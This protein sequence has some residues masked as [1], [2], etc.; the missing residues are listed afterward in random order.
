MTG[1]SGFVGTNLIRYL[2]K[3]RPKWTVVPFQG[4]ILERYDLEKSFE[5]RP[6]IV[7]NL[8]AKVGAIAS[9]GAPGIYARTNLEGT[10]NVLAFARRH[11]ALQFIQISTVDVYGSVRRPIELSPIQP[12][13]PYAISK[14]AADFL[15]LGAGDLETVVLRAPSIYGPF[16]RPTKMVPLFISKALKGEP[17]EIYGDGLQER[18]WLH[19]DD[20]AAGIVIAIEKGLPGN[21]YNLGSDHLWTNLHVTETILESLKSRSPIIHVA[22]KPGHGRVYGAD[23]TKIRAIGFEARIPFNSGLVETVK[24]YR[25]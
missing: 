18:D 2:E 8:A 10:S 14:A 19:I 20:V 23:C 1:A 21:I 22:D 13:S 24:W 9:F 4:D 7:V 12:E 5:S 17:I 3:V 16:D 25:A 11:R 15:V 6:D